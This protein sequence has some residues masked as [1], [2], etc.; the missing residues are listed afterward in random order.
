M[1]IH[2]LNGVLRWNRLQHRLY[3]LLINYVVTATLDVSILFEVRYDDTILSVPPECSSL[4]Q[5]PDPTAY[6]PPFL[7]NVSRP[8]MESRPAHRLPIHYTSHCH[9]YV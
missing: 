1:Y 8:S 5:T 4:H 3:L 9:P 2:L 6:R 7:R